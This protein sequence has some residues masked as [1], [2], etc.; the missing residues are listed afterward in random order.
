MEGNMNI[1]DMLSKM[2]PKTLQN[3]LKN[4]SQM[5]TPEQMKQME[6]AIKNI[7]TCELKQK[8]NNLNIDQI[9]KELQCNPNFIKEM[10]KD[11]EIMK[12]IGEILSK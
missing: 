9:Q 7:N 2:D 8:L 4:L 5:L 6:D 10:Q 11:P 3:G 1:Q 12:K